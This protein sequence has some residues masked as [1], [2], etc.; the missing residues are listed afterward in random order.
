MGA[1]SSLT[2]NV[3]AHDFGMPG[4][5]SA[6]FDSDGITPGSILIFLSPS[7]F[8]AAIRT[9]SGFSTR[10]SGPAPSLSHMRMN[11]T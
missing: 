3:S 4:K 8:R 7:W 9:V 10:P 2:M 6:S 5:N 11:F 1:F